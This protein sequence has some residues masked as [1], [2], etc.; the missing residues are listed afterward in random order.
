[1]IFVA[2]LGVALAVGLLCLLVIWYR[3]GWA[4]FTAISTGAL[5]DCLQ[6]DAPGVDLGVNV[7]VQDLACLVLMTTGFVLLIR[8]RKG[9]PRDAMPCLLLMVLVVLNFGRGLSTF[10]LNQAGNGVRG[11][12][13]FT[14]P[15]L[16]KCIAVV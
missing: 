13:A 4:V 9:I 10:G 2:Q 6:P 14:A 5:L 16:S 7:Y 8:Y 15:A 11:F 1:V 3:P 12:V